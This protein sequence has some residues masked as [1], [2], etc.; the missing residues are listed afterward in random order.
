MPD[1]PKHAW[2][3]RPRSQGGTDPIEVS[4]GGPVSA[5]A[6]SDVVSTAHS[7]F[8]RI[9]F[10]QLF[11]SPGSGYAPEGGDPSSYEYVMLPGDGFYMADFQVQ[12]GTNLFDAGEFPRIEASC[13]LS[14]SPDV[15]VSTIGP[16][17]WNSESGWIGGEQLTTDEMAH[18]QWVSTFWFNYTEFEL[19]PSMGLGVSIRSTGGSETLM[20]GGT[21]AVTWLGDALEEVT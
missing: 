7:A 10:T 6:H 4:S 8:T 15:L 19:G 21:V 11:I 20:L 16:E 13:I 5:V 9:E 18:R 1:L 17:S 14:G 12:V 2:T 3:H